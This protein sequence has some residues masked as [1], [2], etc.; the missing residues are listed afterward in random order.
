[1]QFYGSISAAERKKRLDLVDLPSKQICK[2]MR[3]DLEEGCLLAWFLSE[4]A[5]YVIVETDIAKTVFY[6]N[7][8]KSFSRF[9]HKY[10]NT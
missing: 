9:Y 10:K 6:K 3:E 4:K 8:F 7:D 5:D 1:M 2:K